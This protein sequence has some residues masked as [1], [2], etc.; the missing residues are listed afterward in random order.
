MRVCT[1]SGVCL[2]SV[3]RKF[4]G[5]TRGWKIII[6]TFR[7]REQKKPVHPA[8]AYRDGFRTK[9]EYPCNTVIRH[10]V[11]IPLPIVIPAKGGNP[12]AKHFQEMG[13][14]LEDKVDTTWQ[15]RVETSLW[16][17]SCLDW[18]P[19]FENDDV[20]PND[21]VMPSIHSVKST[22]CVKTLDA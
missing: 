18:I 13:K 7:R 16:C 9:V 20:M 3:F 10:H 17:D 14:S 22:S 6:E 1:Q 8:N 2:A 15:S 4:T 12:M 5:K 19:A 11:V 21:A